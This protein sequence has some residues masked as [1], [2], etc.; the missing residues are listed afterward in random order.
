MF[1][2]VGNG[3][4]GLLQSV[5]VWT[6]LEATRDDDDACV[7]FCRE[8]V[9]DT[10][11][12]QHG[13]GHSE[14]TLVY[15]TDYDPDSHAG[16]VHVYK[17]DGCLVTCFG[18]GILTDPDGVC[19][20]AEGDVAV[21]D[22]DG[23]K[24]VLFTAQKDGGENRGVEYVRAQE[25]CGKIIRMKKPF[26]IGFMDGGKLVVSDFAASCVRILAPEYV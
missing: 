6:P 19:A 9:A 12:T 2:K 1:G 14:D 11:E 20:S 16:R 4:F 7:D 17:P 24:I 25:I 18:H 3:G 8:I 13:H 23:G 5:C 22:K 26:G 10:R 21:V 15:I